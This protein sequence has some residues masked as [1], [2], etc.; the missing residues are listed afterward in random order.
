MVSMFDYSFGCKVYGACLDPI[1]VRIQNEC[2]VPHLSIS[3][4]LL[5][6]HSKLIEALASLFNVIDGDSARMPVGECKK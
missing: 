3:R 6:L 1:P 2:D 5:E 4:P